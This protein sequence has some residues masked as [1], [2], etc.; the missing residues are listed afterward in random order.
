[1]PFL[2]LSDKNKRYFRYVYGRVERDVYGM[3]E[4]VVTMLALGSPALALCI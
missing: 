1:M 4:G 2:V 3:V